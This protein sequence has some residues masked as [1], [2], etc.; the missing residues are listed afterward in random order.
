M[1]AAHDE[2][3]LTGPI[4]TPVRRLD[5]YDKAS[6]KT[7]YIADLDFPGLLYGRLI[8]SAR[9]RA[10]LV[11]VVVPSL[12]DGYYYIS[13]K[14]IPPG[15]VNSLSMIYDDWRVFAEGE[16]RFI[17][18]TIGLLVGPDRKMLRRLE[19][20]ISITYEDLEPA[21]TIDEALSLKGGPIHGSDNLFAEYR[22]TKGDPQS[23][24]SRDFRIIEDEIATG[25]QEHA[26]M[27]PQ[28]MVGYYEEGIYH[29][30]ASCQCPFYIRK[31]VAGII[32][33]ELEQIAVTQAPTG[34]AFGGKEHFPDVIAGP[35]LTAVHA[36]RKPIQIVF[37]RREDISFTA[38]RHPS[39]TRFR[40]AVDRDN[41]IVAMD[42]DIVVNG[43]GYQSCSHIVLQR[44]MFSV[45]SVYDIPHVRLHGRAAATNT[46]PSDAFRG[47]GAP[48][49]LF[50]CEM[51]MSHIAAE[52]G[53]DEVEFKRK[54]FISRGGKTVT[55]GLIHEEV[56]LD[57]M[58][59]RVLELSDYRRKQ[60]GSAGSGALRG[61]GIACYNHGGGFTGDGEKTIIKAEVRLERDE[62]N[63][64][65]V[66]VSN[67]EMGQGFET[68]A[69]KVAAK[70]LGIP[71][72]DVTFAVPD[73]AHVP[74]SGPT[75][76]SRSMM[77]VGKLIE[78]AALQLKE[79]WR[80]PG[81]DSAAERYRQ[82][83]GIDWDSTNLQGDAYPAYG[84]GVCAVEVA[85]DPVTCEIETQGIW[86]VHDVGTAIDERIAHGQVH[87][88]V[89]QALGYGSMEKLELKDG[90]FY[91]NTFA[92]YMIPTTLDFPSVRSE[93]VD[94][95]YEYGPF[96]AKGMGELVFDGAAAAYAAAV[97]QAVG[98]RISAIPVSPEYIMNLRR[99]ADE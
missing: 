23:I 40:T 15:G 5:A 73:T 46:F 45:N 30:I 78:R 97:Q 80:R 26:Y 1:T 43:G 31:A 74:N 9:A 82:P 16:V 87:G 55:N 32:N 29:I 6:G 51:H 21:F 19:R 20:E 38:K 57:S 42:I 14:D 2:G 53:V 28:G 10:R 58:L 36:L 94:N 81:P 44:A 50:A 61:V 71:L 86:S 17:G 69:C 63:K 92:D 67:V 4:G 3:F 70:V 52:L 75:V 7:R 18:E 39:R 65:T 88:G 91:Q 27:E 89:I 95:P 98:C 56:L 72:S 68:T 22:L 49:G 34:G 64:I 62:R 47:F 11:E 59:D 37:D 12:P 24:F 66:L 25:F 76:A 13:R 79:R 99:S 90:A 93:L 60:A 96:G 8:R 85:V 48:Q 41:N 33:A 77:V 83:P 35:L 54:H 84:W